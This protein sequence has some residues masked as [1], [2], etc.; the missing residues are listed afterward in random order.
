MAL[1]RPTPVAGSLH[2]PPWRPATVTGRQRLAEL[3]KNRLVLPILLSTMAT[4]T[5]TRWLRVQQAADLLGVSASTVR[6]WA[7]SGKLV[8]RRSPSGPAPLPA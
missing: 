6:R 5:Q 2:R 4:T 1:Q 8:G 7:D 3:V